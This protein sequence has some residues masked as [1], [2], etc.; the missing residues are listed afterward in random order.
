MTT[1]E[2][3]RDL[4]GPVGFCVSEGLPSRATALWLAE[5]GVPVHGFLADIGQRP[6]AELDRLA[7]EL[8]T[9]GL[10]TEVVDLRREMAELCLDVVR[11]QARYDDGYWNTTGASRA[12]LVRGLSA[13]MGRRGL[14]VLG[15]ASVSGGNDERRFAGYTARIRPAMDVFTPWADPA[16]GAAFA[17]RAALA[18]FAAAHGLTLAGDEAVR[19]LDGNLGGYSHE[20]TELE[21]LAAHGAVQRVMSV[22][23][24]EAPDQPESFV[25]TLRSGRPLRIDEE[26]VDALDALLR[27]NLVGGRNALGFFDVLEN[28]LNGTKCRGVYEAPGLDLLGRCV[29]R[30]YQAVLPLED[31]RKLQSLSAVLGTELYAGRWFDE[32][33]AEAR[34]DA[35]TI[36]GGATGTVELS[37]YKGNTFFRSLRDVPAGSAVPRQARFGAGGFRWKVLD[38]TERKE[39]SLV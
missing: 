7:A 14:R 26:P 21:R 23:P 5:Q 4:P 10:P 33:A 34:A 32:R 38:D 13:V 30:L 28:R 24:E 11:Y 27:A 12:V 20:G 16:C 2:N 36:V 37:L 18:A 31:A 39:T 1:I 6:R 29:R 22:S 3:V 9:A 35:D 8:V 15:H 25:L 19:S 17:D